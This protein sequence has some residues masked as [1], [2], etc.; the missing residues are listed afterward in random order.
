MVFSLINMNTQ[1]YLL[2]TQEF[3][4]KHSCLVVLLVR[5]TYLM[6]LMEYI[7]H[8]IPLIGSLCFNKYY[9]K[10]GARTVDLMVY[11]HFIYCKRFV[12][13]FN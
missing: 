6:E 1:L 13:L 8:F 4:I 10:D 9:D 3:D 5:S 12:V 2:T 7:T 11:S